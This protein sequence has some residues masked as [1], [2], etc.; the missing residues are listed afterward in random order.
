MNLRK[1]V[2][3]R[4]AGLFALLVILST[5][6]MMAFLVHRCRQSELAE[7]RL[8]LSLLT[9][10]CHSLSLWD[11]PEDLATLLRK[12][13]EILGFAEYVWIERG[14]RVLGHTFGDALP[15]SLPRIP[16][17]GVPD[18]DPVVWR[19]PGGSRFVDIAERDQTSGAVVHLGVSRH[20]LD[21]STLPSLLALGAI[22]LLILVIGGAL[23][24]R[25]SSQT[26]REVDEMTAA[27]RASRRRFR[28]LSELLPQS[29]F[30][31][32]RQG[33]FLFANRRLHEVT[34]RSPEE[35]RETT[36]ALDLFVPE[37]RDKVTE[38]M[39]RL[40]G[41]EAI[42]AIECRVQRRDGATFPA[43]I[44]AAPFGDGDQP[45]G[46]RGIAVD[47]SDRVRAMEAIRENERR[48]R[49]LVA[50]I[51]GAVYRCANDPDWTMEFISDAI[52]EICG[53]PASDFIANRVRSFASVIHPEDRHAVATGVAE[54]VTSNRAYILEYR[55]IHADGSI[56]WVYEKGQGVFDSKGRL[57]WLDG[58]IFDVTERKE[59]DQRIRRVSE[60]L[61]HRSILIEDDLAMAREVQQVLLPRHYPSF[62]SCADAA[63]SALAFAHQ[64]HP[65]GAV[66]GDYFD[67]LP[68]S[69]T[70]AGILVCDVMGHGLRSALV[71]AIIRGIVERLRDERAD[72]ALA[73]TGLNEGFNAV[74]RPAGMAVFASA[75]YFLIDAATGRARFANA[76]HPPPFHVRRAGGDVVPLVVSPD[77]RE[78]ALG[79]YEGFR[80][81][82]REVGLDEGDA[83]LFYTDGVYEARRANKEYGRDRLLQFV[84][85]HRAEPTSEVIE[86]I[87][88][89]VLAFADEGKLED[90]FCVVGVDLRRRLAVDPPS[91]A[92]GPADDL[93]RDESPEERP[94]DQRRS[95][96]S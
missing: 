81:E 78:P 76:G 16:E 32:D 95:A 82:V 45:T 43:L 7:A 40:L 86:G 63:G 60:E 87:L 46:L 34:G 66:G 11:R 37:D 85:E 3:F 89:D 31:V 80:Y 39:D 75:C 47:I 12:S 64:Y 33:R 70:Q 53:F 55:I 93:G 48:F 14:G 65:S 13:T 58:A 21:R 30:E 15:E 5:A 27:L 1:R 71:V 23:A 62:P 44:F 50:N 74:F 96:S 77:Q 20:A 19:G 29:V 61:R 88:V 9:R 36:S 8:H 28:D 17:N 24:V 38:A 51:P 41:G 94:E 2:F 4:S 59:A 72:P 84:K 57:L 49:S 25:T 83:L 68:V 67:V 92:G 42:G 90:D 6:G 54:G 69:D 18:G 79:V 22:G 91:T 56:R 10:Q 52:R 73:L 35:I 26:T